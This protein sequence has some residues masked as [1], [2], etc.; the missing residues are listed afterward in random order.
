MS[1]IKVSELTAL[2]ATDGAEELLINDGGTSKKVTIDN[3]LH[4]N[5]IR[6]EHYVDGSI[7]TAHIADNAIT[8]AKLG[9]DVIVAEDVAANAITVA[10]LAANAVTT[11]KILDDNVTAAKLANSINTDIA[12]GVAALPKAGGTMTGNVT[13]SS[14]YLDMGSGHIYLADNAQVKFGTSED[15][16]IYHN[17]S[18]SYIKDNGTGNLH[19]STNGDSVILQTSQGNKMIEGI[20][21]GAAN[22]YHN[23]AK[24]FETTATGFK[25]TGTAGTSPLLELNNGDSED[26]DT[27]R[28]S[29]LRFTGKR[30]GGEAT[31]NAQISGHHDGSAD[32]NK[33]MILFS[34]NDGSNNSEKMRIKADGKVGIGISAP[35]NKL[36][37]GGADG[38]SYIK[39]TSDATGH[40]SGDGARI[41]L[42]S[43]DLRIINAES[44]GHMLFLTANTERMRIDNSGRVGIGNT[45]ASTFSG[46][47][48]TLVVGSG[49]GD[50]GM[51]I[52]SG[53]TSD[54]AIFFADSADNNE[55][56]R[57]GLTYDHNTNKMQLRVNDANRLTIDNA[58]QVGIGT[59]APDV[60]LDVGDSDHGSAGNTGIQIQNSQAFATVYDSTNSNNFAGIQTVNHDDTSNRTPTGLTFVHRS[61][62][63]GIAS[64]QS[65][66]AASDRA[67]LRFITRGSGGVSEKM[68]IADDG[69]VGIGTTSPSAKLT[70]ASAGTTTNGLEVVADSLTTG[71]AAHFYSNASNTSTRSIVRIHQDH[72]D[73]SDATA[74]RVIQ[75]AA[76]NGI[77]LDQVGNKYGFYL[78]HSG[79]TYAGMK[80]VADSLTTK[81]AAHFYSDSSSS[82]VRN[83]V[84]IEND[85]A[86]ANGTTMLNIGNDGTGPLADVSGTGGW[87]HN[88]MITRVFSFDLSLNVATNFDIPMANTVNVFEI[89]ALIGYYPGNSYYAS[90]HGFYAYRSDTGVQR[91]ENFNDHSSSNSGSWTVSNPNTTT[92][93]I[94]KVA[95]SASSAARGFVI[96]KYR[97]A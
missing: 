14:G 10:E 84:E 21:D 87:I 70:I 57:G 17:G 13:H 66:S 52:Y 77:Y 11:V 96:V 58:G 97:N 63:S 37:V 35:V 64:I 92:L 28:E 80:I 62:G 55:E 2:T 34:T 53:N 15:L 38:E 6:A 42:N 18:S 82:A 5:S 19:I 4:D 74:L 72:A 65:T 67:D 78:K 83:L 39:F 91:I 47:A 73:A 12:T 27:G 29:T 20:K 24:K 22:L 75:D 50:T 32:D 1:Q 85:N 45:I 9:V 41:G 60:L 56:T 31:T 71:S 59:S 49:S 86:N 44:A 95:G 48:N 25:L 8:S 93:R 94:S 61:S 36:H 89:K 81:Q 33:G 90:I 68:I 43:D 76:A 46:N 40:T 3:V 26:N 30:S 79:S 51:T 69:N 7:A 88:G 54:G 16:Q 23:N